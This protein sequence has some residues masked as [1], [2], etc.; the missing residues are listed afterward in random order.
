VTD[1]VGAIRC[2]WVL[3]EPGERP[4]IRD[5]TIAIEGS[6]ISAVDQRPGSIHG[7]VPTLAPHLLAMPALVDAHDHG[8]GVRT[9]AYGAVDDAVEVW[10]PALYGYPRVDPYL[11]A[12]A[13]FARLARGGVAGA[14]HCHQ[15]QRDAAMAAEAAA[16]ARAAEDVGIRLAFVVPLRDRHRL[17]Y[18]PD[19]QVLALMPAEDREAIREHWT[20]P[21]PPADAQVARVEAVAAE[22]ENDRV[23]VQ[24]GPLAPQWCSDRLL[25]L[26]AER[27]H[28]T[29]R[30]VHMHLLESR[31]QREWADA[32]HPDGLL[33]HLDAIGLLSSRLTVAHG[34]WL[35]PDE[36]RLLS[37]RGVTVSVNTSS[38]LRLRSG[39][40]PLRQLLEANVS[41][42]LGLDGLALDDDDDALRE[43]RL[44]FLL[45]ARDGLD[46]PVTPAALFR[47]ATR[48]GARAVSGRDAGGA[49][50]PGLD[51]DLLFLDY[52]ALAADVLPD[53]A[54]A[55]LVVLARA[56]GRFIEHLM[57]SGRWILRDREL[58]GIDERA[59]AAELH[60]QIEASA[61]SLSQ[62]RPLLQ[63]YQARLREL[64]RSGLHRGGA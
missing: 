17:A 23:Q 9:L 32:A 39:V 33:K 60:R 29:G 47:A 43:L 52:R 1:T 8:R 19:E 44:T 64:Y 25:E 50:R 49:I 58:T 59:V 38:N 31:W 61:A 11:N 40:A 18:A 53:L 24:Y 63:R 35:R 54:D 28:V 10:L 48:T 12:V 22:C 20:R 55:G 45:H 30:R 2:G 6:R 13:A 5:A 21:A 37:E 14:V 26:I 34:V 42:G 46:G 7:T 4:A 62:T 51:A 27:S 41:L 36:S 15:P 3:A 57:V 56:S 16:V